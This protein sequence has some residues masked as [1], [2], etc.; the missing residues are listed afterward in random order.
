M[1]GSTKLDVNRQGM[2]ISAER[3]GS[4]VIH[5]IASQSPRYMQCWTASEVACVRVV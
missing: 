4:A 2:I 5:V 1:I 3:K